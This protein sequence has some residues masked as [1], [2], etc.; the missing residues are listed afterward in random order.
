MTASGGFFLVPE[1]ERVATVFPTIDTCLS[2]C[3]R[4]PSS[5]LVPCVSLFAPALARWRRLLF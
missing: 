3:D 1:K 5:C 2:H 4:V